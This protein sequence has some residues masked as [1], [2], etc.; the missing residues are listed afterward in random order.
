MQA[1]A[2]LEFLARRQKR[3]RENPAALLGL[4]ST[5]GLREETLRRF[6][7]GLA[8]EY[9]DRRK[10]RREN[11]LVAPVIGARGIP[12]KKSVYLNIPGFGEAIANGRIFT[13]FA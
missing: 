2:N 4:L 5:F 10:V 7:C 11:A 6:Y 12:V 3:L 1:A 13:I 9:L 8:E